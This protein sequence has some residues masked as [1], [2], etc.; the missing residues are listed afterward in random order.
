M[1]IITSLDNKTV[2]HINKLKQKKYRDE[3]GEFFVE[4]FKN[5]LDTCAARPGSVRFVVLSASAYE[6]KGE[7]FTEFETVVLA[8]NVFAKLSETDSDQG[9]MSVNAIPK[10]VFP[11]SE[12]C[13]L[14]DR[15]RD[16]GNVG[17]IL[18]TAVACGYDVILNNCADVYSPKVVRSAMSAIV[19]CNIGLDIPPHEL[20]ASGYELIV[21]DMA[22][23]N[24][25]GAEHCDKYC[26]VVGNEAEGVS[27][28]ISSIA[29]RLLALPQK[30]IESLN[31][32]VAAGVMMF[33]LLYAAK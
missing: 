18:R 11:S 22:G 15:V 1:E 4:G 5:V 30:N 26:V 31:A 6:R 24:V 21:A 28:E 7:Q 23:Q 8:N 16:P 2:K 19:K 14:L 32:A 3:C 25:F 20:K 27:T 29:D 9:I 12:H 10:S 13:I 17:T 33:A